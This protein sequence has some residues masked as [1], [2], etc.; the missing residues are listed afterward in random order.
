MGVMPA[1]L[2]PFPS[3]GRR[4]CRRRTP[5][6]TPLHP[7][8]ARRRRHHHHTMPT[9]PPLL[10]PSPTRP[11]K[12][13]PRPPPPQPPSSSPPSITTL[14]T[15]H[16]P[17]R[18]TSSRGSASPCGSAGWA[19]H[20]C[21]APSFHTHSLCVLCNVYVVWVSKGG[22][23]DALARRWCWGRRSRP[24]CQ[25]PRQIAPVRCRPSIHPFFGRST[26]PPQSPKPRPHRPAA[27]R[28]GTRGA[29]N[30]RK[31][32]G[33]GRSEGG[34]ASPLVTGGWGCMRSRPTA[35]AVRSRLP[36]PP[37]PNPK[38]LRSILPKGIKAHRPITNAI[39]RR[40]RAGASLLG[41]GRMLGGVGGVCVVVAGEGRSALF[42]ARL[43]V[44]SQIRAAPNSQAHR[45]VLSPLADRSIGGPIWA[46]GCD[47]NGLWVDRWIRVGLDWA[48]PPSTESNNWLLVVVV[49]GVGVSD[50]VCPHH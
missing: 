3:L 5:V 14:I 49:C 2:S 40:E 11:A 23:N 29:S 47:W 48:L 12:P 16:V 22:W 45:P 43:F 41:G 35:A 46:L 6:I 37:A 10:L 25:P 9:P 27:V 18:T 44:E 20:C 30:K 42:A 15:T 33:R 4:A 39:G 50:G 28:T 24:A 34:P 8:P 17:G 38:A 26:T 31:N 13:N 19:R 32:E 36:T 7:I 1:P 21:G